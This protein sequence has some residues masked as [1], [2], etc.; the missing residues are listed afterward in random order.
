MKYLFLPFPL[1]ICLRLF[2]NNRKIFHLIYGDINYGIKEQKIVF[3]GDS[4]TEGVGVKD[5]NNTY[6]KRFMQDGCEVFG[7]GISGT[8]IARQ[9]HMRTHPWVDDNYFIIRLSQMEETADVVVVFGGSNDFGHGDAAFGNID[10]RIDETFYGALHNLYTA[11]KEK[12]P[13]AII[14]VM[15]PLHRLNEHRI[16]NELNVRNAGCL[17]DYVNIIKEVAEYHKLPVLDLYNLCPIDPEIP[18]QQK[19]LMPDGVHPNDDGQKLIYELLLNFL[20]NL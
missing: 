18:Q 11:L 13:K 7:Y 5:K 20:N 4:I 6:W 19:T 17:E 12:Y 2:Y 1:D 16:Y 8:R 3:L 10:E 14:V 9:V 15:T